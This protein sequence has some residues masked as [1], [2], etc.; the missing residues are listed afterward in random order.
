VLAEADIDHYLEGNRV[1][2]RKHPKSWGLAS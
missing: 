2:P 1:E